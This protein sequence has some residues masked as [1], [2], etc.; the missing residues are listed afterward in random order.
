MLG[1]KRVVLVDAE[2]NWL[3]D[4]CLVSHAV[5]ARG[6]GVDTSDLPTVSRIVETC[7]TQDAFAAQPSR[8]PGAPSA[9]R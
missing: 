9:P 2:G 1:R 8:Q 4:L 5:N 6:F 7:M 3:A